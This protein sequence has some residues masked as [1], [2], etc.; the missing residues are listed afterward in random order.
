[1]KNS[2]LLILAFSL[3][4]SIL[5]PC[6]VTGSENPN[7]IQY[8]TLSDNRIMAITGSMGFVLSVD[9][10][11]TWTRRNNGLP[12]KIVYPFSGEEYRRLTSLYVDPLDP[13][14]IAVTDSSSLFLSLDGGWNWEQIET[15]GPVKR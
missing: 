6:Q 13:D 4:S 9:N 10:G 3:I 5:I 15:G 7:I 2:Y 12:L 1:M 14:R 11:K 8:T